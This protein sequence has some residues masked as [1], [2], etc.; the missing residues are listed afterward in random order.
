MCDTDIIFC[1]KWPKDQYA[2]SQLLYAEDTPVG[3]PLYTLGALALILSLFTFLDGFQVRVKR[4]HCWHDR[5]KD[6]SSIEQDPG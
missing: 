2:G 6:Q 1:C 3:L 4:Q 5:K